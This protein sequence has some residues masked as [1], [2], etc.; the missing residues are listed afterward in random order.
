M[1]TILTEF[2]TWQ[3]LKLLFTSHLQYQSLLACINQL[4][5]QLFDILGEIATA[6]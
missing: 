1:S 4:K 5:W 6:S 3:L 2:K